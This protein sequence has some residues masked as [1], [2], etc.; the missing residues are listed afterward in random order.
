MFWEEDEAASAGPRVPEDVLD[1]SFR[2]RC[3]TLPV[4]HAHPLAQALIGRLP[5]LAREAGAGI[6]AIHVAASGNGW[7]R[8]DAASGELLHL[9][10]RTRMT[11]R[12]PR[13]RVEQAKALRG[14]RLDI[15]GYPLVVGEAAERPLVRSDTL[16]A[17]YVLAEG[18]GTEEAFLAEMVATLRGMG[19]VVRKALCGRE[20]AFRTPEGPLRVR[21][22]MLADLRPAEAFELQRQGLGA[23]R[24]LGC[25]LFI[26]HKGIK[27]L[28][29]AEDGEE[30]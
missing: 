10:R 22:L 20:H 17:R 26:A 14:A 13:E 8:P 12:L 9:S 19:I 4:D 23:G 5:W 6:H 15:A 27:T 25:G 2:I 16:Y 29:G 1:L 3:A 24:T 7:Y 30:S 11:L 21:S 28:K 18:F